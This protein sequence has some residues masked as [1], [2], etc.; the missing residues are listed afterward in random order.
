MNQPIPQYDFQ[1]PVFKANLK[2]K[3]YAREHIQLAGLN[4]NVIKWEVAQ[5]VSPLQIPVKYHIHY[6][7]KSIIGIDAFQNPI[8][9]NH[10]ILEL[11]IPELYPLEACRIMMLTDVWHPNIKS[12]GKFKG[13]VCG[14]SDGF[15]L[16]YD[17]YQLVLRIGEI[18]QYRNYH[19]VHTPPFPEDSKV[20]QWVIEVAEPY[21]IIDKNR[22]IYVDDT[23]LVNRPDVPEDQHH[24]QEHEE[25]AMIIEPKQP[26]PE[27]VPPPPPVQIEEV[28]PPPSIGKF[29][30]TPVL[31][32]NPEPKMKI[33]ISPKD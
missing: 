33:T 16:S 10:H 2:Y 27:P 9:G 21:G 20:A 14:N 24:V 28:P 25:P 4:S 7:F 13:R 3:R 1:H 22:E 30:I 31:R 15:G 29:K 18:L 8:Y 5:T 17:L 11:T 12:E 6:L 26:I 32:P 23:P 19:A